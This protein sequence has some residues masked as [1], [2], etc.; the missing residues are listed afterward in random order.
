MYSV[1]LMMALTGGAEVPESHHLGGGCYGSSCNGCNGGGCHGGGLFHRHGCNGG[2]CNGSGCY[3]GGCYGGGCY[4]SGCNGGCS[5]GH[6]LLGGGGLFHR[7]GGSCCG[8]PAPTT[9]CAPV[10]TCCG[11]APYAPYGAPGALPHGAA[12]AP[13]PAPST[14]PAKPAPAKPGTAMVEPMTT[15]PVDSNGTYVV[16]SAP[17][18]RILG[19]G[20][21]G[22]R[23]RN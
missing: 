16:E 9:C 13:M 6:R 7:H 11:D 17:Q 12:P 4:G 20:L 8:T 15:T 10:A 3:G 14:A 2:G 21:F 1:V 18:R 22:R 19:G 23:N 5:G